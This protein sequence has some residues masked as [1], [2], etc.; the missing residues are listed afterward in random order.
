MSRIRWAKLQIVP[1]D[2]KIIPHIELVVS[3]IVIHSRDV[4]VLVG[5]VDVNVFPTVLLGVVNVIDQALADLALVVFIGGAHHVE[6]STDH[7]G[8]GGGAL[9]IGR[10]PGSLETEG[11]RVQLADHHH[12]VVL[13]GGVDHPQPILVYCQVNVCFT[14]PLV[15]G[16]VV[17]VGVVDDG[18]A[19]FDSS[20]QVKLHNVAG[21]LLVEKHR[22]V[23]DHKSSPVYP[24]GQLV[25]YG[26][27]A[28]LEV[29][30]GGILD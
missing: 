20:P 7:E 5:K 11:V 16:R 13:L 3:R 8:I 30:Q 9:V 21:A 22:P 24:V 26:L 28:I 2:V 15:R 4:L 17:V 10:V 29:V 19:T 14:T 6:Y 18:F 27:T 25:S 12:A 23:V 1:Q